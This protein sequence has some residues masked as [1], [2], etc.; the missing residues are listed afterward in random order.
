MKLKITDFKE[1]VPVEV[2]KDYDTK[3]LDMEFVDLHYL[4][5]L[6]MKGVVERGI[7]TLSFR[8]RLASRV[9]RTCGRCLKKIDESMNRPFDL[10]YETKDRLEIE[11]LDDLRD[12]VMLDHPMNYVCKDSC[13]GLCPHCGANL[14]EASCNCSDALSNRPLEILKKM[15]SKRREEKSHGKS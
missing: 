6:K 11:T 15:L 7:D 1:G 12:V 5:P 10:I 4:T 8:G 3:D 9:E 13:K 14:N 2:S